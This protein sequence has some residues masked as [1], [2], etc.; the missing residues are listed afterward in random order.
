VALRRALGQAQQ[1]RRVAAQRVVDRRRRALPDEGVSAPSQQRL[2]EARQVEAAGMA[3]SA[4]VG[5]EAAQRAVLEPCRETGQVGGDVP[6]PTAAATAAAEP[7]QDLRR[8]LR[9]VTP[10]RVQAIRR[11]RRVEHETL[12]VGGVPAGV[13]H[14]GPGSIAHA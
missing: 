11:Y 6:R 8:R 1:R 2:E 14:R 5:E 12:D 4:P 3:P 13:L 9:L 7:A 10:Q